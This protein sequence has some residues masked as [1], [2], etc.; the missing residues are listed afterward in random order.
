MTKIPERK[1]AKLVPLHRFKRLHTDPR[2]ITEKF[3][4]LPKNL[5]RVDTLKMLRNLTMAVLQGK[6]AKRTRRICLLT[7]PDERQQGKLEEP[8]NHPRIPN[9]DVPMLR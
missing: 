8:K 2:G 3:R 1:T 4:V 9:D 7:K 6:K 5:M